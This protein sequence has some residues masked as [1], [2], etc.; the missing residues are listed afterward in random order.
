MNMKKIFSFILAC[1]LTLSLTACNDSATPDPT[2]SDAPAAPAESN[3]PAKT[4][5]FPSET[6]TVIVPMS[7]GGTTDIGARL[8]AKELSQY[9]GVNVV[10]ENQTGAGGWVAWTDFVTGDYKDGYTFALL[11]HNYPIGELDP[12]NPRQY[13]L[14]DVQLLC[15]QVLDYNVMAIRPNETRFHDLESFIEYAKNNPVLIG[16]QAVGITDGDSSTAEWFNKNFG[17]QISTVPVDGGSETRTMFL[18]GDT[19][20]YFASVSEVAIDAEAGLMNAVCVFFDERSSFMP[21]VPTV[22]ELLGV[23]FVSFSARYYAYPQGVDAEIVDFMIE[24]MQAVMQSES[25]LSQMAELGLNLDSTSGDALYELVNT[26]VDI[27]K[28]IWG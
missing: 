15:N 20:V 25:Y 11:N 23:E 4:G 27:R 1:M 21:D 12:D 6:I 22:K 2:G 10:V 13:N 26:Q 8:L 16:A 18:A 9:L 24:A 19:D 3:G 7:A 5:D 17:T 28:D 14:D